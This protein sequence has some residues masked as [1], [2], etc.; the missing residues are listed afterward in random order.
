MKVFL[1]HLAVFFVG[2]SAY[3]LMEIMFRGFTHWTMLLADG[4]CSIILYR[5]SIGTNWP[6]WQKWILGGIAITTVEFLFGVAFNIVLGWNVWDYSDRPFNL[7]GQ[8]CLPFT[9]IWIGLSAAA[10][11][12]FKTADNLLAGR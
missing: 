6:L 2:G 1:F 5:I 10:C 7:M 12:L 4:I 8:I 11:K 3:G 9:L